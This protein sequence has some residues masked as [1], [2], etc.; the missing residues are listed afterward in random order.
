M[1]DGLDK[2]FLMHLVLIMT[3]RVTLCHMNNKEYT[4]CYAFSL[5]V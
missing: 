1:L 3:L 5:D 4:L 2:S